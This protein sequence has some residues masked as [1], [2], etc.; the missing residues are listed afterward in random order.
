MAAGYQLSLNQLALWPRH[1]LTDVFAP[2]TT[3]PSR[4]V[5]QPY[6]STCAVPTVTRTQRVLGG[7]RRA[8][9]RMMSG[10]NGSRPDQD[11]AVY[12]P[13]E[14]GQCQDHVRTVESYRCTSGRVC[15]PRHQ[16]SARRVLELVVQERAERAG[17]DQDRRVRQADRHHPDAQGGGGAA[18]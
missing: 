8:L 13:S 12:R 7:A 14:V 9:H 11:Q 18:A 4:R 10:A 2:L 5:T 6:W 3:R 17:G 1:D 15:R 16:V